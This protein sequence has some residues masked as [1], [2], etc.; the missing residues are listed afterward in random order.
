MQI[1]YIV[2]NCNIFICVLIKEITKGRLMKLSCV[3]ESNISRYMNKYQKGPQLN[4]MFSN[5]P[6]DF[7]EDKELL[8]HSYLI[9]KEASAI[10]VTSKVGCFHHN[11]DEDKM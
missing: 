8:P 2:T 4:K 1:L 6:T 5:F 11:F 3:S 9:F 7:F 10:K